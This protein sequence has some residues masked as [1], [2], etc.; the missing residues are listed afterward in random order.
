MFGVNVSFFCIV[1]ES[2]FVFLIVGTI[3]NRF[4]IVFYLIS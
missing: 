2:Y 3:I 4:N 1:S